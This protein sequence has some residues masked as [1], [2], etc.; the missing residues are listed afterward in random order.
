MII[1]AK[2]SSK[3]YKD[4]IL[5]LD[6]INLNSLYDLRPVSFTWKNT[7]KNDF[8]LIAEEV[9]DIIPELVHY[10]NNKPESVAY[11]KLSVLLLMEIKKLKDEIKQLKEK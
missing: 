9:S 11:D 5:D 6:N 1:K 4:N 7:E 3:R 10:E 2:T 8:G